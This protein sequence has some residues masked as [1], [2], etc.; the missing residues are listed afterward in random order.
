MAS[1]KFDLSVVFSI[2]NKATVP[3]KKI[4]TSFKNL[5]KSVI[6]ADKSFKKLGRSM[7]KVGKS[8][9]SIGQ[10]MSL[11]LTA[12]LVLA[13]GL[14]IKTAIDFESA[15][16]GVKKTVTAS[17]SEFAV[18]KKEL[19]DLALIIPLSTVE[20][21]GIAEAAGQLGIKTKDIASFTKVMANLGA[22]TNLTSEEAAITIA[23]LANVMGTSAKD[24]EKLGSTIVDLGNN[25]ATTERDILALASRMAGAGKLAGL[26]EAEVL[27]FAAS[28]S[29]VGIEAEAGGTAFSQVMARISKELGTGSKKM[30]LFSKVSGKSVGEFEKDFKE[31]G[32]ETVLEFIEGLDK[33]QK[34]GKNV[35]VVLDQLGLD[36]IR[37]SQ[38][39]LKAALAGD[40]F[41]T[42]IKLGNK[43]WKE[44]NALTQEAILRYGTTAS[45][46][47]IASNRVIQ[48]ASTFGDVLVPM[49]L[50]FVK[51]MQPVI[52]WFEDLSPATKKV[53]VVIGLLVAAIGPLIIALGAL[54]ASVGALTAAA[55]PWLAI[56]AAIV[57][58]IVGMAIVIIK[59]WEPVKQFFRDLVNVFSEIWTEFK[60]IKNVLPNF[61][62][63]KLGIE[64]TPER[65]LNDTSGMSDINKR[66]LGIDTKSQTDVN[67]K[68]SSDTGSNASID[69][70]KSKGPAN[71]KLATVGYLGV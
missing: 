20:I 63:K 9:K 26:T 35:N 30:A 38:V 55:S 70:V 59:A 4:A 71:V 53:I 23:K 33:L 36:G 67:I 16:T 13:G 5:N 60:K 54:T 10:E 51:M 34:E 58:L 69:K 56:L 62:K 50:D 66:L 24:F 40:K 43:A 45:K 18:L 31:K 11:K 37:I 47:K 41:R 3:A 57:L 8:M 65:D 6:K 2:I 49:L 22:T 14:M 42:N 48:L 27:S 64:I 12:P 29:S 7:Q 61:I 28:L 1:K 39:L 19:M 46:L 21:F 52:K 17:A 68:V 44:N 32:A 15:W 25:T